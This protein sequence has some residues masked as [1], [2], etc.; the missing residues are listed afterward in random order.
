MTWNIGAL[1]EKVEI[2]DEL[3]MSRFLLLIIGEIV[4]M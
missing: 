1:N 3:L 4:M 2:C